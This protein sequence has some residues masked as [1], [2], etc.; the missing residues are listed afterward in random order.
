MN[1]SLVPEEPFPIDQT[2]DQKWLNE[3][4]DRFLAF[5]MLYHVVHASYNEVEPGLLADK[6]GMNNRLVATML[7]RIVQ[8][9]TTRQLKQRINAL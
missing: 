8:R 6:L 7:R 4:A 3:Q 1:Y 9:P 2:L 5:E